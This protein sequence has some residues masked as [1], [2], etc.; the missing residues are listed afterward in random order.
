MLLVGKP[1]SSPWMG[2]LGRKASFRKS[3]RMKWGV[4]RVVVYPVL[5]V[6]E[7]VE[8]GTPVRV[9][10]RLREEKE[11]WGVVVQLCD[12][13]GQGR[14]IGARFLGVNSDEF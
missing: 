14:T 11:I 9:H 13:I 3:L 1:A 6:A 2:D 5:P 12:Y 8:K 4:S 10:R 7:D